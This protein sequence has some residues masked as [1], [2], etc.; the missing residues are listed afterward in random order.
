MTTTVW[1]AS[2]QPVQAFQQPVDV[3]EVQA[4]RRLVEDVEVVLAALQLAEFARQLDALGFAA[5]ERRRGLAERE[6]AEAEFVEHGDLA[7]DGRARLRRTSS[8][9]SIDM[10]STSA[11]VLP[12]YVTSSV[13]GL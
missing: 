8:P 3:G 6:V 9:S 11:M 12:W 4:R 13:S 2:D 10:S 7:G 5:G 1:P